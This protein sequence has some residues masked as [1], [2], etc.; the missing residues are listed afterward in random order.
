MSPLSPLGSLTL[1]PARGTH[2]G[3]AAM[4]QLT[5]TGLSEIQ[6]SRMLLRFLLCQDDSPTV[7]RAAGLSAVGT[8]REIFVTSK[9]GCRSRYCFRGNGWFPDC[10]RRCHR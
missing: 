4:T 5:A 3:R 6:E 10:Y 9:I 1:Q 8:Q 7:R 2:A